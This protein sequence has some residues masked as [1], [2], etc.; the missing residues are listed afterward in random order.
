MIAITATGIA[1][2][3]GETPKAQLMP[4]DLADLFDD[5]RT[6]GAEHDF[7]VIERPRPSHYRNHGSG[8]QVLRERLATAYGF[9]S[10][11]G[12]EVRQI[13][14]RV[15]HAAEGCKQHRGQTYKF[16]RSWCRMLASKRHGIDFELDVAQ[17]VLL[18]DYSV[19]AFGRAV[20]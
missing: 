3:D 1:W 13:D 4:K 6:L 19:R 9:L 16:W 2:T 10:A 18:L 12:V 17:A 8:V 15:W 14:P 5:L 20:A 7:C 11:L